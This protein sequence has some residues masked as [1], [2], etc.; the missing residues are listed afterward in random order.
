M[1]IEFEQSIDAHF[2]LKSD[3]AILME[4]MYFLPDCLSHIMS[5]CKLFLQTM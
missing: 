2:R 3:E 1:T 4:Q 5:D